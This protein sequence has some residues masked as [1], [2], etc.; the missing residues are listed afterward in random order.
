MIFSAR[1]YVTL[2]VIGVL[3]LTTYQ[4]HAETTASI[5]IKMGKV[6]YPE[7]RNMDEPKLTV[8]MWDAHRWD[9]QRVAKSSPRVSV[10]TITDAEP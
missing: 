1:R 8:E 9:T 6:Y 7:T 4:G 5:V 3:S 10:I 2:F